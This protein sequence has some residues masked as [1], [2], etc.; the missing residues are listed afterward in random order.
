MALPNRIKSPDYWYPR[1]PEEEA[2]RVERHL[3]MARDM[4]EMNES[5]GEARFSFIGFFRMIVQDEMLANPAR[6]HNG[7]LL[8]IEEGENP[9]LIIGSHTVN[10]VVMDDETDEVI[11]RVELS[12]SDLVT[13]PVREIHEFYGA[14]PTHEQ[15]EHGSF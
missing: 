4:L 6:E 13:I 15:W 8:G 10:A 3:G 7:I 14:N 11:A 2:E 12:R 5:T 9:A 1:D